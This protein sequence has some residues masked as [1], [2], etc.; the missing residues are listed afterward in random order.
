MQL[1]TLVK[2]MRKN[3]FLFTK[4]LTKNNK[5]KSF[6][7]IFNFHAHCA[8]N[9]LKHKII[10][11][12]TIKAWLC[13]CMSLQDC[14]NKVCAP[15]EKSFRC[16]L[17][18]TCAKKISHIGVRQVQWFFN[19]IYSTSVVRK[20]RFKEKKSKIRQLDTAPNGELWCLEP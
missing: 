12:S 8:P 9:L 4:S 11:L 20:I 10:S 2:Q 18:A 15:S 16:L 7:T 3:M 13:K 5:S 19:K 17:K 14:L 1:D 6:S